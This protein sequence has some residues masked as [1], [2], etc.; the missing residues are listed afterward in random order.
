MTAAPPEA[1]VFRPA[2]PAPRTRPAG[3]VEFLWVSWR[4]PLGMWSERHFDEPILYGE[5]RL[6]R[7]MTV[8]DPAALRQ[9]LVE[10]AD[11]FH[12]TA[13]Q[14]RV[15]GPL[16][17]DG[18]FLAEDDD[19]RRMRRILAPVFTPRRIASS[20]PRMASIAVERVARWVR[21]GAPGVLAVD[22]EMTQLTFEILSATLFSDALGGEAGEFERAINA[23]LAAAARIEPLDVLGAPDWVPRLGRLM[24]GGPAAFFERRVAELAQARRALHDAGEDLPDDLLSALVKAQ[25]PETGAGLSDRQVTANILTFILAGHETTARGLG[26]ALWLLANSPRHMSALQKE[27]DSVDLF[28]PDAADKLVFARAVFEEAMRLYPPAPLFTRVA[29]KPVTIAGRP[30][31]PGATVLIAPWVLHRHRRLWDDPSAFLPERFLP[32]ARETIDRFAYIP[33]GGG[34]RICIGASFAMQ[35]AA[36]ALGAIAQRVDLRPNRGVQPLPQH[37]ITLRP[38]AEIRLNVRPR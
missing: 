2:V 5:S 30:L 8:S 14:R 9:V 15:L 13:V 21:P 17:G 20:A 22:S 35:E 19:W 7:A 32:Q 31:Q 36:L 4:D 34:P 10:H 11:C 16:I 37:R 38:H 18:V 29:V 12:K 3:L 33:F 1:E 25:D 28:D 23:Y 24:A 6:G 27:A 26:W